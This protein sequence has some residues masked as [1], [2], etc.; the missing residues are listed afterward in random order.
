MSHEQRS[1]TAPLLVQPTA[2]S[3]LQLPTV[4][5]Q[6]ACLF[7]PFWDRMLH[8]SHV[9]QLLPPAWLEWTEH[10][11]VRLGEALLLALEQQRPSA[12]CCAL[13]VQSLTVEYAMNDD[14]SA[15]REHEGRLSPRSRFYSCLRALVRHP[16]TRSHAALPFGQLRFLI[17]PPFVLRLLA[18]CNRG[19]LPLLHSLAL[20]EYRG[21]EMEDEPRQSLSACWPLVPALRRVSVESL[22]ASLD[23]LLALPGIEHVDARRSESL[24]SRGEQDT[25]THNAVPSPSLRALLLPHTPYST[26]SLLT[27]AP[28]SS[29]Q[30]LSITARWNIDALRS[31]AM[32]Q[33]LT[34]QCYCPL[35]HSL[36]GCLMSANGEPLL[37][38]LTSFRC[39]LTTEERVTAEDIRG[40]DSTVSMLLRAYS[41]LQ[42]LELCNEERM[43]DKPLLALLPQLFST[44]PLLQSLVF[45]IDG[46]RDEP[47]V[48]QLNALDAQQL[49]D[50]PALRALTLVKV[51][52]ADAVLDR[53]LE[54]CP[55]L[56]TLRLDYVTSLSPS[57]W[58]A[59]QRCQQLLSFRWQGR[60]SADVN[61]KYSA[62]AASASAASPPVASS[63]P[64]LSHLDWTLCAGSSATAAG[65]AGLLS[66]LHGSPTTAVAIRM[67]ARSDLRGVLS[68]L[69]ALPHL[70]A[71]RFDV[72]EE[73]SSLGRA[74]GMARSEARQLS[75]TRIRQLLGNCSEPA[76][77][78]S[79]QHAVNIKYAWKDSP[80]DESEKEL[81][82]K[83]AAGVQTLGSVSRGY[84]VSE[85]AEYSK[86][87]VFKPTLGEGENGGREAFLGL[88]RSERA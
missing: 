33:S 29:L 17:A 15:K 23:E 34:V 39:T 2:A 48:F 80:S 37:P 77:A 19:S 78:K 83:Y 87:S 63:F 27:S 36:L 46:W 40:V 67:P 58:P 24:H 81:R 31:L 59:I 41:R 42:H 69:A 86:W 75:A 55:R 68:A 44:M 12:V 1:S 43:L 82:A 61:A 73:S 10:D 20:Y 76:R 28:P 64:H 84:R 4:V 52:M 47:P 11:H 21:E 18:K 49:S 66:T 16:S 79:E 32:L 71:L 7:L 38:A 88:L 53:L 65:I 70:A 3:L 51:K 62:I 45:R 35:V 22:E 5:L 72:D 56:L 6:A 50:L 54:C 9:H 14:L 60:W 85:R 25:P 57:V 13:R 74:G 30:H 8:L 26:R